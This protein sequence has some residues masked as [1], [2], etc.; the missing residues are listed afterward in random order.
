M[1]GLLAFVFLGIVIWYVGWGVQAFTVEIEK[2]FLI[3]GNGAA[4]A[5]FDL[6]GAAK[7]DLRGLLK[8]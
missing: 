3:Q 7:L 2:A 1:L 5:A 4:G 6:P 8:P